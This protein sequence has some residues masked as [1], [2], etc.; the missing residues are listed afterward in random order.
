VLDDYAKVAL[1]PPTPQFYSTEEVKALFSA[2]IPRTQLYILLGLNLGYTQADIASL[3][4]PMINWAQGIVT[5]IRHKTGQPQK[6][7]LWPITAELLKQEMTDARKSNLVLLGKNDN[8]LIVETVNGKGNPI[9]LDTVRLAFKQLKA[10]LKD[11]RGFKTFRKTGAD[12]IAKQYQ[13]APHLVDLYLAH[14]DQGMR[15]HYA[16][17]YFDELFKA[18]DWLAGHFGLDKTQ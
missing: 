7:K 2:A 4:H 18:T 11:N 16:N 1:P 9:R 15:K 12:A 14:S 8:P 13:S 10:K 3:E 17:Q 6:A 5:R